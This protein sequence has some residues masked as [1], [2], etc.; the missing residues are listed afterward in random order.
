MLEGTT[1]FFE[2]EQSVVV[3]F[4]SWPKAAQLVA[5]VQLD[6]KRFALGIAP[7]WQPEAAQDV[8]WM[9]GHTSVKKL[10]VC[11]THWPLAL[12]VWVL[13]QAPQLPPQ[14]S[15]PHCLPP[16]WGAHTHCPERLQVCEPEQVPHCPPQ[17]SE[18]HTLPAQL[19]AQPQVPALLQV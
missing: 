18:P 17:P 3:A 13:A 4:T 16:H 1:R 7:L 12:Q 10:L 2:P 8:A 9:M 19:G 6:S 15:V 14:P 5:L 11:H